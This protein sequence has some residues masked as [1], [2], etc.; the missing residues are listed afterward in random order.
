[1]D[2]FNATMCSMGQGNLNILPSMVTEDKDFEYF[3]L[4]MT[5][6]VSQKIKF[7]SESGGKGLREHLDFKFSDPPSRD[8]AP[9]ALV[10]QTYGPCST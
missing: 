5:H 1:M 8:F 2:C 3:F 9:T 7:F 10:A 6:F 4:E